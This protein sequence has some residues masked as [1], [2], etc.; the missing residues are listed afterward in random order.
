M[1]L[2]CYEV[3]EGGPGLGA[4]LVHCFYGE[5]LEVSV[6]LAGAAVFAGVEEGEEAVGAGSG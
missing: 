2:G 1:W 3:D 4:G 5:E 6:W